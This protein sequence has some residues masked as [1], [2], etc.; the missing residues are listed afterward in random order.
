LQTLAEGGVET[1]LIERKL[2]NCKPCGGA[3]PLC[4]V[5]EFDLPAEIID[6]KVGHKQLNSTIVL[7]AMGRHHQS[8]PVRA[9]CACPHSQH[10]TAR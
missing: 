4:M 7:L 8:A 6:R 1:F 9:V 2:D 3:I 5:Q 10:A